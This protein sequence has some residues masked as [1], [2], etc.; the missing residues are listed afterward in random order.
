MKKI[1]TII[2][3][4]LWSATPLLAQN[5]TA[6]APTKVGINQQF[7]YT[8]TLDQNGNV[9]STNF[10]NFTKVGG[11]STST[12]QSIS[13]VNGQQSSTYTCT[14]TY[15]LKPTKTGT[16]T[17]PGVTC[18][19]GGKKIKSNAVTIEVTQE[20]QQTGQQRQ[21]QPRRNQYDPFDNF[22]RDFWGEPQRDNTP[23]QS[24]V[25]VKASASK[26]TPY[27]GETVIITY[28]LYTYNVSNWQATNIKW[29]Q[30]TDLWSYQMDDPG[31]ITDATYETINGKRYTVREI[32][33]TAVAPQKSGTLTITP[34]TID[35]QMVTG[36]G[37]YANITEKKVTS[38]SITLN[39]QPLPEQGKDASFIGLVGQF[40]LTSEISSTK[41]NVNDAIDFTITISG[42]GSLQLAD[43]P[44]FEFP[45]AFDVSEPIV[46][47]QIN[48]SGNNV[49]GKRIL[50]Y[51]L[52]P[53]Q[54][55][56]YEIPATTITYF[57]PAS[58]SYKSLSTENYSIEVSG[59]GA[60]RTHQTKEADSQNKS[61]TSSIKDFFTKNLIWFIL[62]PCLILLLILVIF[63]IRF[64]LSHRKK[65]DKTQKKVRHANR[66]ATR[67]LKKARKLMSAGQD[68]ALFEEISHALWDYLGH[69]F[70]IPLSDLSIDA[71]RNKLIDKGMSEEDITQFTNTLNDCEYARFAPGDKA[72]MMN[73]MYEQAREFIT[74]MEKK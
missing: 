21:Q 50:K 67:R 47:D 7:N 19:V 22:F 52:I 33:R 32:Y 35:L 17:I 24:D 10:G 57:D 64:I 8:V 46:D 18:N 41:A 63:V 40:N 9:S 49:G 6:K 42:Q 36:S 23:T 16:Q 1:I 54:K 59:E 39:A 55:G 68:A 71:V 72:E 45:D 28:K 34:I 44:V 53:R 74:R 13:F 25:F 66:I 29:P 2:I 51:V 11:P 48:T 37:F 70:R 26:N 20:D 15:T 58:K 5:C 12:S 30:Q 60:S 3:I 56:T 62:I 14:F 4:L 31:K 27:Y 61:I 73:Q 69:K 43:Y 38:N 65:G